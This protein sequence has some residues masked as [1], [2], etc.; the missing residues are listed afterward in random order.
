MLNKDGLPLPMWFE[1][2]S[3]VLFLFS[4]W[5]ARTTA[6]YVVCC[7]CCIVFGFISIAL[8]VLRRVSEV[9]LKVAEKEG[10]PTLM[11]G[12]F[13]VYHNAIR[14]SVAFLNYSWDYMLMLVAMTFNV[15]IFLSMLG[16]MALGFLT[17]GGYLDFSLQP[18]KV[19]SGCECGD[20]F[21]CGCHKGQSCTC[22]VA[23]H[24]DP[25]CSRANI[26]SE[27]PVV[28][29]HSGLELTSSGRGGDGHTLP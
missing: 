4:W 13:P 8:K 14:G 11:F 25:S 19:N 3:E 6:Q 21:S 22:C 5:N 2:S 16:G 12:S 1:A 10:K 24:L 27:E 15:G 18:K 7:L 17:I 20:D 29:G 23:P 26:S 28:R 9:R